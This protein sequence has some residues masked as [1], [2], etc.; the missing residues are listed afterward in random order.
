MFLFDELNRIGFESRLSTSALRVFGFRFWDHSSSIFAATT[1]T[2]GTHAR[3]GTAQSI[4][5]AKVSNAELHN[6]RV[7]KSTTERLLT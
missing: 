7:K 1:T 4:T 6:A 3:F 5:F 2:G